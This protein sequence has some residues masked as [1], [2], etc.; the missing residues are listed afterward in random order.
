MKPY[1]LEMYHLQEAIFS[2]EGLLSA[3]YT[4]LKTRGDLKSIRFT[5]A[6]LKDRL[7]EIK[8]L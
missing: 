1:T 4:N 2:L 5:V 6:I 7:K 3:S 8:S